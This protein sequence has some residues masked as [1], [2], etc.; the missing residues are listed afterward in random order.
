MPP[1]SYTLIHPA[2]RLSDEDR[3]RLLAALRRMLRASPPIE[4]DDGSGHE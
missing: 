4:G 3:A 2:A 1:V